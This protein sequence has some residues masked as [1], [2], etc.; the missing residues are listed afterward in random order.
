MSIIDFIYKS[1]ISPIKLESI[2]FQ[3]QFH[4]DQIIE[5]T[6]Q[7]KHIQ[8]SKNAHNFLK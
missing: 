1:F 5:E 3:T 6:I 7:E 8:F 4:Y 2:L